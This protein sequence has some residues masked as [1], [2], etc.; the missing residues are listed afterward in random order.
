M[1]KDGSHNTSRFVSFGAFAIRS[2]TNLRLS[3]VRTLGDLFFL[4]QELGEQGGIRRTRWHRHGPA[5]SLQAFTS[6]P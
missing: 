2:L 5:E 4:K 6:N 3:P 1:V